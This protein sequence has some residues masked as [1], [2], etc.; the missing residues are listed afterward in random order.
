[1]IH[2]LNKSILILPIETQTNCSSS[3]GL[4]DMSTIFNDDTKVINVSKRLKHK[5]FS[6]THI[7]NILL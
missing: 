1:M 5:I 7:N 2:S 6:N 3:D 4:V